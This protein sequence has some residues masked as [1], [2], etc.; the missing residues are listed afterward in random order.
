MFNALELLILLMDLSKVQLAAASARTTEEGRAGA[1]VLLRA[2][3]LSRLGWRLK[4]EGGKRLTTTRGDAK[5]SH[6]RSIL[7]PI[8][9]L[10]HQDEFSS[11]Q[12]NFLWI[13]N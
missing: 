10:R 6:K 12:D 4:V 7:Q 9:V 11:I 13:L 1:E 5:S 8:S 3:R 2:L